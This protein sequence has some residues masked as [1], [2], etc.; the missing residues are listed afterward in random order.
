MK[1]KMGKSK[2]SG[3]L[4]IILCALVPALAILLL[5]NVWMQIWVSLLL[6][7]VEYLGYLY[8]GI[9]TLFG[10]TY[11][12]VDSGKIKLNCAFVVLFIAIAAILILFCPNWF[13]LVFFASVTLEL[14]LRKCD[15]LKI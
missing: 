12:Y 9:A 4:T 3:L 13:Y 15:T 11:F 1:S 7:P 10:V 5:F 8:I 6:L 14:V 2:S